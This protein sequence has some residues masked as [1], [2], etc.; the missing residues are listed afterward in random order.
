MNTIEV[1]DDLVGRML[2]AAITEERRDLPKDGVER[3]YAQGKKD[4]LRV[5]LSVIREDPSIVEDAMT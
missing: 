4:A 2:E 1:V 5:V 3:Q